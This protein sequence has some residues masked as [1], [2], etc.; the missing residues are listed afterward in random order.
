M[1]ALLFCT[2]NDFPGYGNLSNYS[3]KGH[4]DC[5]I[6]EENTTYHQLKHGRKI[7]YIG[8]RRFLKRNHPYRRLKKAFNGSHEEKNA[9][10]PLTGEEVYNRVCNVNVTFGKTQ[11]KNIVKNI[12]KK[13]SIFFELPYWSKLDVRHCKDVTHVEKNVCDCIIGT[14]LNIKGKAKDGINARK[15]LVE[16]GV[17]LELQPQHHGKRTYLPPLCHTLSKFETLS[18]CGCMRGVKV[19][20]GYS[21]NIKSL[22]SMQDLKLMGLKSHDCHVLM[23]DF[24]SV[25]I[26]GILPK[27]V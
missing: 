20:Q 16:M 15:D 14:L 3:V 22:V 24:L 13:K 25:S 5:P 17:H 10:P 6:C 7:S 9:P 18:F 21:S 19:Q 26:R 27:N 12:W 8:H 4:S 11:K 1:H 23:Q 2:I